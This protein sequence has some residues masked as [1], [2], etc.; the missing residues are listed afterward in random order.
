MITSVGFV[1]ADTFYIEFTPGG[2]GYKVTTPSSGGLDFSGGTADV[3]TSMAPVDADDD[4]FEFDPAAKPELLPYRIK[5]S[6]LRYFSDRLD[7][8]CRSFFE[9]RYW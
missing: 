1:N 7:F 6:P 9:G 8:S 2:T 3:S 5:L 4:R